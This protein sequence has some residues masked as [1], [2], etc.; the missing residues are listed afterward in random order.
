MPFSMRSVLLLACLVLT[1]ARTTE[2]KELAQ[3]AIRMKTSRQLKEIFDEL[4]ISHKGLS[5]EELKKTAYKEDAVARWEKL[6]PEKAYKKPKGSP[7]GGIPGME[8]FG[9]GFGGDPKMEEMMRQMR[10]DFSGEKDPDR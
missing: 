9:G 7:G 3:K 10:G 2:E 6:H 8:G 1:N 5:K 4:G